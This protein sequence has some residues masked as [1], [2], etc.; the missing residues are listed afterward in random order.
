MS[1]FLRV[2]MWCELA[3]TLAVLI[4]LGVARATGAL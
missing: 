3:L 2:T 4:A 1:R